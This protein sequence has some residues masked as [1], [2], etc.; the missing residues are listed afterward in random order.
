MFKDIR[1]G[2]VAVGWARRV[3]RPG[4]AHSAAEPDH[5]GQSQQ[6]SG[7]DQLYRNVSLRNSSERLGHG[8]CYVLPSRDG[9]RQPTLCVLVGGVAAG[10]ERT[11]RNR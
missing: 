2:A 6:R 9:S 3:A 5:F 4:P 10:I 1:Q 8:P 11:A 7:A